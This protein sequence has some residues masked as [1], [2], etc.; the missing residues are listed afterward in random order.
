MTSAAFASK[1]RPGGFI[2]HN[3]GH[4]LEG[5]EAINRAEAISDTSGLLQRLSPRSK[6]ISALLLV[7]GVVASTSIPALWIALAGAVVL[8]AASRVQTQ[9]LLR[10]TWGSVL[11]FTG[12]M[13]LPS[14]VMTPGPLIARIPVVGWQVTATG[15]HIFL[16]LLTRAEASATFLVLLVLTTPWPRLLAAMQA[17][18]VP[19]VVVALFSTTFRYLILL[20]ETSVE[21][22]QSRRSRMVGPLAPAA[23]RRLLAATAGTL[24]DKT[25]ALSQEVHSA[26]QSRGF[27]GRVYLL[28]QETA[29]WDEALAILI[30]LAAAAGLVLAH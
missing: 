7:A 4:L 23:Q 13:M 24:L 6:I 18:K 29:G 22:F 15:F 16:L 26:M 30:S 25:A 14:L 1:H 11:V 9:M 2:E 3:L 17:L 10:L 28:K 27:R 19:A 12:A 20:L 5:L 21:M 8:A